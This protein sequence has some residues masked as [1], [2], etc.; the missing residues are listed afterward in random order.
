M[1]QKFLLCIAS[2][3]LV[4]IAMS[5]CLDSDT[6][7]ETST[8][9]TV[10]AFS[11]DTILGVDYIF[12]IDQVNRLIYNIDSLP[13]GSDTIID[14]ILIDTFT[15]TGYI[16]SGDLDTILN[17]SNYQDLTGATSEA[18]LR[19]RIHAADLTTYRDYYLKIN[20]HQQE[21]DSLQWS[22]PLTLPVR[23][24]IG[25][26]LKAVTW[27]GDL[28]IYFY[29]GVEDI[30]AYRTPAQSFGAWEEVTVDGLPLDADMAS[31]VK[32]E[33]AGSL[34]TALYVATET[35]DVYSSTDGV[36]WTIEDGLSGSVVTLVGNYVDRL[37]GLVTDED[38]VTWFAEAASDQSGWT[39]GEE[40]P[41]DFPR[42]NLYST[43]FQ[44]TNLLYQMMVVGYTSGERIIPWAYDGTTWA[45]MD[46]TTS[47]N[48]YCLTSALGYYPAI[49]YHGGD[50][51]MVGERLRGIYTSS[52]GLAWYETEE[53]VMLPST[54]DIGYGVGVNYSLAVD[55]DNFI[56]LV[57]SSTDFSY[58]NVWRGRINRLGFAIQ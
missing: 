21:P 29:D 3:L 46:P 34:G 37:F 45:A 38:G 26:R 30:V 39:T 52:A 42:K 18:G 53:L 57:A 43:T 28:L 7:Y 16:T 44:T 20:I 19:F 51:Y 1:R 12:S 14:S 32:A 10:H 56:Y 55:E 48:T 2:F 8:D 4:S 22:Q 11:L 17:I 15:V 40:A 49:V 9:P 13:V 24:T 23:S 35:G 54:S 25:R 5:S 50:F 31:V 58:Y 36:A 27:E 47:Y 6:T 33:N 41:D